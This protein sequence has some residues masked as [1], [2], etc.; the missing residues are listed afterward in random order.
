VVVVIIWLKF[1]LVEMAGGQFLMVV[2][3]QQAVSSLYSNVKSTL[4]AA[5]SLYPYIL[6]ISTARKPS[7]LQ[8]N[9]TDSMARDNLGHVGLHLLTN[10][11][12][13]FQRTSVSN[14]KPPNRVV[15]LKVSDDHHLV[16]AWI[17]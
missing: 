16:I 14:R 12:T 6:E 5:N 15:I 13:G 7:G 2:E 4:M 3:G 10:V 8:C 11:A 1:A 9:R 17:H